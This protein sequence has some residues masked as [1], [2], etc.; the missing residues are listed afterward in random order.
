MPNIVD[1]R[2]RASYRARACAAGAAVGAG[3]FTIGT[4]VCMPISLNAAYLSTIPALLLACL[5]AFLAQR[6]LKRALPPS[7]GLRILLTLTLLAFCAFLLVGTVSLALDTLLPQS[8]LFALMVLT[9]AA[10]ALCAAFGGADRLFFALRFLLPVLLLLLT[11]SALAFDSPVGLFPILGTGIKPLLFSAFCALPGAIPALLL[12]LPPDDLPEDGQPPFAVPS[13][14]F[15]VLHVLMG[16]LMGVLLL[17]A[18]S[19]SSPYKGIQSHLLWGQRMVI[20]SHVRPREGLFQAMLALLQLLTLEL[21]AAALLTGCKQALSLPDQKA[22][23]LCTSAL[24]AALTALTLFGIRIALWTAP[25]LIV[26]FCVLLFFS[27]R[28]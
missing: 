20:L 10:A 21:S 26:P 5:T 28:L 23:V 2:I 18:L 1:S 12:F 11:C 7:R 25:F 16:G 24:F 13:P 22:L 14:S 8:Q 6:R 3:L 15:F 4:G 17:F 19:F 27:R 9:L